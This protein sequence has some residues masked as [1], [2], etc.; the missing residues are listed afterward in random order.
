MSDPHG[1]DYNVNQSKIA[2]GSGGLFGKGFMQGTQIKYNFVPEKHTDFIFCTVGEEWGF[3]G[4]MVVLGLLC[5]LILRLM[6][7]GACGLHHTRIHSHTSRRLAPQGCHVGTVAEP[8]ARGNEMTEKRMDGKLS[9]PSIV[10][11]IRVV[12]FTCGCG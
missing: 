2:I 8:Q 11:Y 12:R 10:I 6:R 4:S 5:A 7:M 3:V 1:A 9:L